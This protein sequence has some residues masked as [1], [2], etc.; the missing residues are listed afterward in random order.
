MVLAKIFFF[1]V[2]LGVWCSWGSDPRFH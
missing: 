2:S 1:E